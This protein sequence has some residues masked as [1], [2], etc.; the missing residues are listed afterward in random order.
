MGL[1]PGSE[2]RHVHEAKRSELDLI[3]RAR[4]ENED[5]YRDLVQ[6][7]QDLRP[8]LP[9][10]CVSVSHASAARAAGG[11]SAS[12]RTLCPEV[13]RRMNKSITQ[14]PAKNHGDAGAVGV[15][16]KYP[17][18]GKLRGALGDSDSWLGSAGAAERT[19]CRHRDESNSVL[20][21]TRNANAFCALFATA[22]DSWAGPTAQR[23]ALA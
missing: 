14:H 7:S 3:L 20:F 17:R 19:A 22:T 21:A 2:Q 23:H 9:A 5:W 11:H 10:Q 4:Q 13:C 15:A 12:D 8:V 18:A 6:H 16:G 1:H